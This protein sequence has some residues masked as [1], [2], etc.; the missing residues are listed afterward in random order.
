MKSK[1]AKME[2]IRPVVAYASE[3][4]QWKKLIHKFI[5]A[6][7][8]ILQRIYVPIMSFDGNWRIKEQWS[9]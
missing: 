8:K 4:W 9:K 2:I 7:V 3:I 6:T 1:T 5:N